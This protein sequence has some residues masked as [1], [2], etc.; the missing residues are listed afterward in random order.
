VSINIISYGYTFL[1]SGNLDKLRSI[2]M[3]DEK[4]E[5]R[6]VWSRLAISVIQQL[7]VTIM[8]RKFAYY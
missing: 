8:W 7:K 6:I 1:K 2:K 3:V 4:L 5:G